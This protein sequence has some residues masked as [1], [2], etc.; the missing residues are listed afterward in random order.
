MERET[1]K[2]CRGTGE[3]AGAGVGF[4]VPKDVVDRGSSTSGGSRLR[5]ECLSIQCEVVS[6]TASPQFSL[7]CSMSEFSRYS[8]SS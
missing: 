1:G 5:V 8:N 4:Q 2:N 3:S 6:P 7:E